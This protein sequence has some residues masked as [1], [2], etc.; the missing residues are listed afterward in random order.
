MTHVDYKKCLFHPVDFK[1][2]PYC[3][4]NF[5]KVQ[6]P[7]LLRPQNGRLAMSIFVVHTPTSACDVIC[8]MSVEV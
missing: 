4:V 2:V 8:T 1:K 3:P 6:C 5:K 7:L